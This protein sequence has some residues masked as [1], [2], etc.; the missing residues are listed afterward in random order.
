MNP[1][2]PHH[3]CPHCPWNR[4]PI[5][6][7][8]PQPSSILFLG[9]GPARD[10]VKVGLP[11][12]GRAGKEFNLHYLPL[13]GLV[14]PEVR[15]DNSVHCPQP[16]YDNPSHELARECSLRHLPQEL[17]H[18]QPDLIV[19]MG[20][21]A[22]S[23]ADT[24]IDLD[25]DHG[26]PQQN[27][28]LDGLWSGTVFPTFHPAAGLHEG[29]MILLLRQDFTN[30]GQ[31]LK[32][33]LVLPVD[34]H[35]DPVLRLLRGA[36]DV[37][38]I[39]SFPPSLSGGPA[40]LEV[41]IDTE[42]V[43]LHGAP[44]CLSFSL[45]HCNGF[46]ILANDH[47]ALAYFAWWLRRWNPVVI[48]HHSLHDIPV[49]RAMGISVPRYRDTMVDAYHLANV[50]QGLKAL[51]WRLLGVR[52]RSFE[53]T[54][55]PHSLPVAMDYLAR[56][57]DA[58][59]AALTFQHTLKSGPRKGQLEERVLPG[60]DKQAV[61]TWRKVQK[62]LREPGADPWRRWDGWHRHDWALLRGVLGSSIPSPSIVH[63]PLVEAV[64]YAALDAVVTLRVHRELRGKRVVL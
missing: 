60:A 45:D 7:D 61:G 54:V 41:A 15:V 17:R 9:E 24:H 11:F 30:L 48:L 14:R 4:R 13:A 47:D 25:V 62:C 43:F 58:L 1:T 57:N 34:A 53:D 52:M 3:A 39:L 26:L 21:V 2:Y 50:P 51:G 5:M 40:G 12:M 19:L 63:V 35:P 22:C 33:R 56:A 32:G 18:T 20:G 38:S 64:S 8:G 49:L 27:S 10:E 23:L 55:L 44:W 31:H 28:L 37:D 29:Q 6:G 42:S 59:S 16:N 46:V 36:G